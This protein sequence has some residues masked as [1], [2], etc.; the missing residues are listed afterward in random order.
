MTQQSNIF[1]V[2][3]RHLPERSW[4]EQPGLTSAHHR[5]LAESAYL[6]G[7]RASAEELIE[8]ALD[9]APSKVT[10]AN[11]YGLRVLAATV[12]SDWAAALRWGRGGLPSSG[13]NGRSK[14]S[15]KRTR[16]KRRT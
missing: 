3:M 7:H 12:A 6:T 1:S 10:K 2:A 11:L 4:H 9:H 8:T 14:A 5:E 16:P 15:L 13:S